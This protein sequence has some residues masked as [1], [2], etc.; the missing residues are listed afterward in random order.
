[1]IDFD[2]PI[3]ITNWRTDEVVAELPVEGNTGLHILAR[4]YRWDTQHA[5]PNV[6]TLNR[7]DCHG[8]LFELDDETPVTFSQ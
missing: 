3:I 7:N 5:G 2:K 1:M 8:V 6:R 4:S